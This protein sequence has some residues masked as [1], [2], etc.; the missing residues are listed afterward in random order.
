MG[1]VF[2]ARQVKPNRPMALKVILAGQL[3]NEIGVKRFATE[4]EAAA[5]LDQPGIVPIY[6]VG[7]HD[8]RCY[9]SMV[10]VEGQSLSHRRAGG[11]HPP[12]AAAELM[13]MVAEAIE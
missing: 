4:A 5:K 11:P 6:K 1:V 13:V 12:R 10:L 9:L 7:Q 2:Q 8:G 3:A